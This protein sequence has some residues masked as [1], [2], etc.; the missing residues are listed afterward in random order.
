MDDSDFAVPYGLYFIQSFGYIRKIVL[1]AIL[2]KVSRDID[3]VCSAV[4]A[5]SILETPILVGVGIVL[6]HGSPL[7]QTSARFGFLKTL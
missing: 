1:T 4:C 2:K 5:V 6:P 3:Y 7:E